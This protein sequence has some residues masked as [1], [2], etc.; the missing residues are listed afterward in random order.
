MQSMLT[1][2]ASYS[3]QF[4]DA[5]FLRLTITV[6]PYKTAKVSSRLELNSWRPRP[7]MLQKTARV[8]ELQNRGSKGHVD[9]G[10]RVADLF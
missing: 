8:A 2:R 3:E 1:E 7:T 6:E 5:S 4:K 10:F 9:W